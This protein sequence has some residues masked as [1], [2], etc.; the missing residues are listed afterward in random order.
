MTLWLHIITLFNNIQQF[1]T[2]ILTLQKQDKKWT[3]VFFVN[4]YFDKV[5]TVKKYKHVKYNVMQ[6]NCM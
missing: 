4:L 2:I 1:Y 6:Q 5:T 3:G